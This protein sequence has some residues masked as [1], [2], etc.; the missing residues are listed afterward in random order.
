MYP[1][2]IVCLIVLACTVKTVKAQEKRA[3]TPGD[4][5]KVK[6]LLDGA[7]LNTA[8]RISPDG[9]KVAY[10]VKAPDIESNHNYIELHLVRLNGTNNPA[11]RILIR[12]IDLSLPHWLADSHRL[13]FLM[14]TDG[15]IALVL[16][17]VTTGSRSV[18]VQAKKNIDEYD[19]SSDGKTIVYATEEADTSS[20]P[21]PT[22]EE[23]SSGYRLPIERS[24]MMAFP[25][26]Q[27]WI[28][29]K[30]DQD[31]WSAPKR[32]VVQSLFD[33]SP[34]S[35]F[36]HYTV[37]SLKLSLAPNRRSLLFSFFADA[38]E[39]WRR[40][41]YLE[42]ARQHGAG[43]TQVTVLYE[44]SSGSARV[45]C[46]TPRIDT[47]PL[48]SPN[49]R[50]VVVAATSPIGS[51]W[52]AEDLRNHSYSRHLFRIESMTGTVAEIR[53][54]DSSE[55]WHL[56]QPLTWQADGTLLVRTAA[57]TIDAISA[58][59][60]SP[61]TGTKHTI[62]LT[63]ISDAS[64]VS[65]NGAV[66]L[67]D[68]QNAL[69]PPSLYTYRFGDLHVSPLV[70]L[71]PQFARLQLAMPKKLQWQ[72]S[73]GASIT[74]TLFLPPN[75]EEGKRYPLVIQ[76]KPY[77][78]QFVCDSGAD[79][80]PSFAPQPMAD[81]GLMYLVRYIPDGSSPNDNLYFPK[82]YPG[83]IGEAAFHMDMWDTAIDV[84]TAKGMIDPE[85]VGI[86]GYSHS[87]WYTEFILANAR[88]HYRAATI[89]DNIQYSLSEYWTLRYADT[90][91]SFDAMYGGPPYGESLQNWLKYSVSFNLDKIHTPIL[92]EVMGYGKPYSDEASPPDN[93][94][95]R[96]EI[97]NGLNRLKRPIELY[98]Y[99]DEGHQPDHP[100]ARLASLQRNLDWYR[101]WLQDAVSNTPQN[102]IE[103]ERW[104][105]FRAFKH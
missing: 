45:L 39:G 76:T 72:T 36:P 14:K 89:T 66:A 61:R 101:F 16:F 44:I 52:E 33:T 20:M 12:G 24:V 1:L 54:D 29:E 34:I 8:I 43:Y 19:V 74:G 6:Y 67:G 62:P 31:A 103:Y 51:T 38:P 85:K 84:L 88:H 10:L 105:S 73:T 22:T 63:D 99:P 53:P 58:Y 77:W 94:A 68:R 15:P 78:G 47:V 37:S 64:Q 83:R 35:S 7:D 97:V 71:N 93:L 81:V 90:L 3:I 95:V 104:R 18:L 79:H 56:L 57:N 21:R 30:T 2:R 25:K 28:T 60:D 9:K 82:G 102:A 42:A 11:D 50:Y 32:I 98:Y 69:N 4:C 46:P 100:R 48:W 27:L 23:K 92:M 40:N 91:N 96:W 17:D 59:R 55:R 80:Y 26:K 41:P 75:Y 13:T 87:G 5:V 65:S 49:S 70:T 86:I